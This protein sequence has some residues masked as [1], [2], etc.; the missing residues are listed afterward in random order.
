MSS[1]QFDQKIVQLVNNERANAG[2]DPLSL[3]SQLDRAANLH[4]DEMVQAD[5]M[6]HQLP[7]EAGLGDRVSDSG[8]N[9]NYVS[10]N[11]AAGQATPEEVMS[12]WMNSPKHQKN[13]LNPKL[14]HIGV[15]YDNAPDDR[16]YDRGNT[17]GKDYDIYWTQVFGIESNSDG[18]VETQSEVNLENDNSQVDPQDNN[19]DS[20]VK[21]QPQVNTDDFVLGM[22]SNS[23]TP[24]EDSN[25]SNTETEISGGNDN[26]DREILKLVNNERANAGLDSLSIDSQLDRAADLHTD[27]MIQADKMSHQLP[28][29]ASLGD[30]VSDSGYDWNSIAENIAAGSTTPEEVMYNEDWGWMNSPGHRKNILNADFT[31]LGVG[32]GKADD[33]RAYDDGNTGGKD[34]DIYWTQ[35]FATSADV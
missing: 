2:L 7:G 29:E 20:Q 27:E 30:R 13:I 1:N 32:Y 19:L 23:N 21:T 17:G 25:D 26:F 18:E 12:T 31:H 10:E 11:V 35:V 8:Y 9:W 5:K 3:D 6:S 22:E 16:S 33:D 15:G 34:Y 28:G 4:T 14:T 24:D